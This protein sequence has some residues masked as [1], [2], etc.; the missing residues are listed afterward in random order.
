MLEICITIL[1]VS[2]LYE[3][4]I[5]PARKWPTTTR[6]NLVLV[7]TAGRTVSALIKNSSNPTKTA[8]ILHQ[9]YDTEV[10]EFIRTGSLTHENVG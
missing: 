5:I 3:I 2:S 9:K 4:V 7:L 6:K 1:A 8:E 10:K